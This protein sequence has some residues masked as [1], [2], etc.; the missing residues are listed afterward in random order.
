M[1][2]Y[3][4]CM[5][6][7]SVQLGQQSSRTLFRVTRNR[8][9]S[10]GLLAVENARTQ[11]GPFFVVE[12]AIADGTLPPPS[13]QGP[14]EDWIA[15]YHW[16][17][18]VYANSAARSTGGMFYA[19]WRAANTYCGLNSFDTGP[20]AKARQLARKQDLLPVLEGAGLIRQEGATAAGNE[21]YRLMLAPS[22]TRARGLVPT[23]VVKTIG[24]LTSQGRPYVM[25]PG[26]IMLDKT[27]R[28]L[29][30]HSLRRMLMA[31]YCFNDMNAWGG[32]D[33]NHLRIEDEQLIISEAFLAAAY[34]E[35][36]N[37]ARLT[38][39]LFYEGLVQLVRRPVTA[40]RPYPASRAVLAP[41]GDS[42]VLQ[43]VPTRQPQTG[44]S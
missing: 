6:I 11:S 19:S 30:E 42:E 17:F 1:F 34:T 2:V 26:S 13:E 21:R 7:R 8:S 16:D 15:P 27:W 44:E 14:Q 22:W 20:G 32:V 18:L 4:G 12:R 9:V 35:A 29:R 3:D 31:L 5:S 33:I 36:E 23:D 37:V 43:F 38:H 10:R 40:V 28:N 24:A 39:E 41:S 25:V